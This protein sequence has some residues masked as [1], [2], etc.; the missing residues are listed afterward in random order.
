M[1]IKPSERCIQT[2]DTLC[3]EGIVTQAKNVIAHKVGDEIGITL[4]L[5]NKKEIVSFISGT[6]S[7]ASATI[8]LS[9]ITIRL[10][11]PSIISFTQKGGII[12]IQN[13]I[14]IYTTT[15]E[16][17]QNGDVIKLDADSINTISSTIK[18]LN[19]PMLMKK[20]IFQPKAL[21]I[22]SPIL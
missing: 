3:F 11:E 19:L 9:K 16:L 7:G 22:T 1:D 17:A 18:K 15:S 10:N 6:I 12:G 14:T 20:T 5:K 8:D 21:Q 13:E 2:E 4:D